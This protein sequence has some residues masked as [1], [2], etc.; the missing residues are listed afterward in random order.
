[1]EGCDKTIVVMNIAGPLTRL[2]MMTAMDIQ[3]SVILIGKITAAVTKTVIVMETA[4]PIKT[5][6]ATPT[7]ILRFPVRIGTKTETRTNKK[8]I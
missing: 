8:R 5:T 2:P 6:P 1:M 3:I 7:I 4:N